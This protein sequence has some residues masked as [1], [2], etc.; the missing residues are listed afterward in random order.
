LAEAQARVAEAP[1]RER[2]WAL[3]ALAQY[4]AGR[5][6][7]ALRSLHQARTVLVAELGIEPGPDLVALEQAILRQ[8]PSLVVATALPEAGAVCPYLGLVPYGID[9]TDGFF[10]RDA[11]V[12]ACLD[13][14]AAVGVLAVVGPSGSGKS[15]LVRAG[16]AAALQRNGRRVVV[17]TPGVHPMNALT[18]LPV[19]GPIP[20]LVVDQFEEAVT[21]CEDPGEQARF[22]AAVAA[23]AERAPLVIAV[24]ADRL[25]DVSAHPGFARLLEPGLHLLSAMSEADLRAAIE[26]PARQVGLLLEPGLVDLLVLEVEGEPGAL[27]LLSHAL[28]QTWQRR[29][30]R[31]LTV[32]G[33]QDTGG[34]RGSVAQSAEALYDQVPEEQRPLLRDLLLRLVTPTPEGEPVRSRIPRRTV[35]TN[36]EHEQLI[37][38]LVRARLVTSDDDSVELAHESLARAWP[39]LR[40]WLDDDVEGQRVFRHLTGAADTW[41]TMGRPDSEL[42][43]G[44]R[45]SRTLEWQNRADPDLTPTERIFLDTSAERERAEAATTEQRLRQQTRQNRRLRALLAGAAVLLVVA[46]AAGL[47]AVRQA[48][49]ADRATIAAD[50]RR[51]GA[52][53]L[54]AEDIDQ[55]L[56]LAVEG[57]R[58]D[59][60]IDTRANLLAALNRSPELIGSIRGEGT[61]LDVSDDGELMAVSGANRGVS[62]VDEFM[63]ADYGVS[64][65]DVATRERVA[66]VPKISPS[67]LAFRPGHRQLAVAGS[68]VLYL[69]DVNA[70]EEAPV[71][72][73]G[74][75]DRGPDGP[76]RL[77]YSADG[78]RLAVSFNSMP[79][80]GVSGTSR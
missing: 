14:L 41:D 28:H 8:D 60:S 56:L 17:I 55:S 22:F 67:D 70:L 3:L 7:D 79:R 16:V 12:E 68:E 6:A 69:I 80:P 76:Y 63:G 10:G 32:D 29:E 71:Q 11:E 75:P 61:Q 72:L 65:Y 54:V 66:T 42:Y 53:A 15:S 19:S 23:H 13:R 50:A 37:E 52:Q 30:G 74:M 78:E 62:R 46:L 51:V 4:Q 57:M 1:L 34:I 33:Y 2:R 39:R 43:R 40:S 77:S 18:A 45:L 9:D 48:N 47:L 59:D 25:G 21:L 64:L 36:P 58:L 35:A 24:R 31:T 26:G 20:V 27:P 5:Q 73:G 49:R 38:L 44:V